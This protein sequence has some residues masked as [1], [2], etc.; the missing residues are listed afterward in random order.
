M[1]HSLPYAL[2]DWQI[3]EVSDNHVVETHLN[4]PRDADGVMSNAPKLFPATVIN[5]PPPAAAFANLTELIAGASKL[6]KSEKLESL[7]PT[8]ITAEFNFPYKPCPTALRIT[9]LERLIQ[10]VLSVEV[11]PT[12]AD[13]VTS[14]KPKLWPYCTAVRRPAR[15]TPALEVGGTFEGARELMVGVSYT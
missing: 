6:N 2:A 14:H 15:G 11:L 1:Y 3:S 10:L 9:R 8:V 4:T 13:A 12:L 5:P 7:R